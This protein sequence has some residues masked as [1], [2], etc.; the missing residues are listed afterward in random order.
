M[1]IVLTLLVFALFSIH[2]I[3]A[4]ESSDNKQS[5]AAAA[6]EVKGALENFK[7]NG[8]PVHPGCV[9]EFDVALAD[10]P[11]PIVRAVDIEAC[12]TGNEFYMP[13]TTDNQ[14]YIGYEY[15]LGEGEK[16][17]FSYKYLG[18]TPSGIRVL[19]TRSS[20]G[21]TMVAESLLLIKISDEDYWNFDN[22]YRKTADKRLIMTCTG[23]IAL[24]D[25]DTG[26]VALKGNQ[27]I[28]GPSQYRDKA[29][30]IDLE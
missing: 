28:L 18:K 2:G 25:R 19:D 16:G 11:P 7:F 5:E 29:E 24:G 22:E 23:Q 4:G 17:S 21:G 6:S 27:L 8:K 20:G 26:D 15:D 10:S 9:R 14:G 3:C 30:A 13:F 1:K 12:V